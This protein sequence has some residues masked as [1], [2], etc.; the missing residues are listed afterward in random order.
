MPKDIDQQIID[1]LLTH[2]EFTTSDELSSELGVSSKTITR[3]VGSI[4]KKFSKQIIN[5][6]RGQGYKLD[7]ATYLDVANENSQTNS[8]VKLRREYI[9]TKLLFA[10]PNAVMIYDLVNK[11][12]ISE[13]V[14]QTD[15]KEIGQRLEKWDLKLV[16]KQRSLRVV[17]SEK[18]VRDA[19]IE[20]VFH[21]SNATDIDALK[22]DS[23]SMNQDDFHMALSQV[24]IAE[25]TLNGLLPYP[26]NVNFFAHIYILLSRARKYKLVD[27]SIEN[28]EDLQKEFQNNPEIFSVCQTIITNIREYLHLGENTLKSEAYYLFEYLVTSRFNS[29]DGV[30]LGDGELSDKVTDQFVALVSE[31]LNFTFD[32]SIRADIRSHIL[33]MISRLKMNISLP[34]ALLNSIKLEYPKVFAAT[35]EASAVISEEFSLPRISDDEAGFICLYFVKYYVAAR[36]NRVKTYVICTTGIGTS[37]IISTKI[38]NAIPEI[39]IVGMAST[40]DIEKILDSSPNIELLISTVPL[41]SEVDVPVEQVSAFFTEKDEQ[42]V[43]KVVQR[44]QNEKK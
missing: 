43:K 23:D 18:A 22:N 39:E 17:G 15:V 9:V 36:E 42:Q 27:A 26:Y 7:Y 12:Y 3:H 20:V 13:S 40:F 35:R 24:E 5:A 29:F 14:L 1:Y 30:V 44:I 28:E 4:N 31:K 32:D 8:S 38:K 34:N 2:T 41:K 21:L 10:A 11:L 37:G 6:K 16:R 33:A 19:L 25:R